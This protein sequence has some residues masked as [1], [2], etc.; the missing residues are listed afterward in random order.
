MFYETTSLTNILLAFI[1][2]LNGAM[3]ITLLRLLVRKKD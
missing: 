3:A 1:A 2:V